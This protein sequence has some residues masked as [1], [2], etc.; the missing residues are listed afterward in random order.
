MG[1]YSSEGQQYATRADLY[2]TMAQAA[3]THPST[4]P[5]VQD[6]KLME[7][8]ELVDGYL[9]QQF[10]L[11]L[12]RWGSD[13][14]RKVCDVAA[15]YLV[16]V[17]GFNPEADGHYLANFESAEKWLLQVSKGLISPDVVD[18]STGAEPGRQADAAAPLVYSPA[19]VG[20]SGNRTRGTNRR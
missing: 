11:P 7:A 5:A 6:A 13:L 10:Q 14:V 8:S 4:G 3:L 17:R 12:T 1:N 20:S 19:V 2:G 9:R 16:C 18:G 15:Y